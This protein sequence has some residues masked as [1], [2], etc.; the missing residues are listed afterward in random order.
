LSESHAL[1]GRI[2]ERAIA[3]AAKRCYAERCE[4]RKQETPTA[5]STERGVFYSAS[6]PIDFLGVLEGRAC[7]IEAKQ[8]KRG[9]LLRIYTHAQSSNVKWTSPQQEAMRR[10][11]ALGAWVRLVIA[12]DE[13]GETFAIDWPA[14]AVFLA[15]PWRKSLSLDWCRAYGE[16]VPDGPR[17]DAKAR[18][19]RF[20]EGVPHD[21][22][23]LALAAV[24]EE[25]SK[26]LLSD[27]R[28]LRRDVAKAPRGPRTW[29]AAEY[30]QATPEER[31]EH[32]LGLMAYGAKRA[33]KR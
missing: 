2:L 24:L 21:A 27:S 17:F 4:L 15:N 32:T 25:R 26:A 9:A 31:F 22:R 20:L 12:F 8:V 5:T 19:V 13:H 16:L 28:A 14:L 33:A 7:A 6:A 18:V 10:Q 29:T 23:A 1:R 30:R 11:H 3:R